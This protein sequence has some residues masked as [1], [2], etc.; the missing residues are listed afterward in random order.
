MQARSLLENEEGITLV[1]NGD[2]P[3]FTAKPSKN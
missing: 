3:L 2:H 1:L